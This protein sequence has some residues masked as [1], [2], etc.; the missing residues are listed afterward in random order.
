MKPKQRPFFILALFFAGLLLASCSIL[1]SEQELPATPTPLLSTAAAPLPTNPPPVP[2][3][4]KVQGTLR[5]WHSWNEQDAQALVQIRK[6]FNARYPDVLFDILYIPAEDLPQRYEQ[7]VLA[8]GGPSIVLGP[9]EWGPGFYDA[10]SITSLNDKLPRE[11]METLN[12]PA[13]EAARYKDTLIGLPYAI[14]GVTLYRNKG[15]IT[16]PADTFD[17]LVTLQQSSTQ[18]ETIGAILE[19]S[20]L[21]SGGHLEGLGGQLMDANG[22]P[23]FNNEFG[24]EW[25]KLLDDFGSVAPVTFMTDQDL[26]MFKLGRAGWIIDGTW[27]LPAIIE[28]MG[29]DKISI[30]PWPAHSTGGLSGYVFSENLY[31][32]PRVQ[33]DELNAARNFLQYFVSPEAQT[34]LAE[35]GLI[36]SASGITLSDPINGPLI[37]QAMV[38]LAGGT[39]YPTL[40]VMPV[41]TRN[42]DQALRA[43]FEEGLPAQQA[44][45]SAYDA[46]YSELSLSQPLTTTLS[47]A[48]P[49]P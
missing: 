34:V 29:A 7:E 14:D 33:G 31:L 46:I 40:Q 43:H 44:L 17:E 49:T 37:M 42:L 15:L 45:Q 48:T 18:G 23:T 13:V 9:A 6:N 19:R 10:G 3:A 39:A 35:V 25:M 2:T 27:N 47:T 20:F 5:L 12:R 21:Y 11:L 28:T 41:Y 38:A 30:D 8:G 16:I 22:L 24:L 26:E 32:N 4:T 36:P 1:A